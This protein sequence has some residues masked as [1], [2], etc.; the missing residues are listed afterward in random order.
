MLSPH[1]IYCGNLKLIRLIILPESPTLL[2]PRYLSV[3]VHSLSLCPFYSH[4]Q[5]FS[6]NMS[7]CYYVEFSLVETCQGSDV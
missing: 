7:L 6:F 4:I 3:S 5:Q 2:A 1:S